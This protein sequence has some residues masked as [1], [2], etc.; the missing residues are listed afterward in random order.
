MNGST[1]LVVVVFSWKSRS[2]RGFNLAHGKTMGCPDETITKKKHTHTN[3]KKHKKKQ[4]RNDERLLKLR[5]YEKHHDET[6]TSC[7]LEYPVFSPAAFR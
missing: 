6:I 5:N 3:K 7:F 4:L 2:S 1:S